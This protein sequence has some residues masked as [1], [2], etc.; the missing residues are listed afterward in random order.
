M[1][2]DLTLRQERDRDNPGRK[3]EMRNYKLTAC[4]SVGA[5]QMYGTASTMQNLAEAM[6]SCPFRLSAP[7]L[8]TMGY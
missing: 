7:G 4:P 2:G 1:I 8:P 3:S 5:C 6:E